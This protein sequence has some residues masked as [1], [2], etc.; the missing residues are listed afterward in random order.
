MGG[1]ARILAVH[2]TPGD[3]YFGDADGNGVASANSAL[4]SAGA[5]SSIHFSHYDIDAAEDY[6]YI[7][8]SVTEAQVLEKR[9][10]NEAWWAHAVTIWVWSCRR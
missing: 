4:I 2:Y 7:S 3:I 6:H 8:D 9:E 5:E 10:I 1:S